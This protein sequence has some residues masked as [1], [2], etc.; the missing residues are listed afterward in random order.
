M[1]EERRRKG[2]VRFINSVARHP[3]LGKDEVV[4][5]FLSHPSVRLYNIEPHYPK[6]NVLIP[7]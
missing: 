3:V 5:A 2:L 4:I 1:F 7:L 6:T